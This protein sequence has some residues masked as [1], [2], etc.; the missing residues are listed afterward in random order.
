MYPSRFEI[1]HPERIQLYSFPTPNGRKVAIA[2][3]ELELPYE[4]HLVHILKGHQSDADYL[5]LSPNGKIPVIVDPS[6]PEGGPVSIMESGAILH[7][8]ARKTGKLMPTDPVG[9][10]QV[11]QWLFFQ[12]GH[13]GPMFGQFGHFFK[14]AKGKTDSY[15]QERYGAESKRLLGVLDQRL[16]GRDWLVDDYSIADIAIAPWIAGLEWYGAQ[17]VLEM[18]SFQNVSAWMARFRERPAVQRGWDVPTV[19]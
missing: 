19:E 8:L 15:G 5:R 14:F 3:E 11:L 2:L 4:P 7:Y 18:D 17:E 10:N 6:G 16:E 13:I 12:V 9:E 1:Q